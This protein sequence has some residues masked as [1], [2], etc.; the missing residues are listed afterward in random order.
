LGDVIVAI[1]DKPVANGNAYY[2]VLESY[3]IGDS[4]TLRVIRDFRTRQQQTLEVSAKL[5]EE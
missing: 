1:D 4:V 3:S 5:A 2:N